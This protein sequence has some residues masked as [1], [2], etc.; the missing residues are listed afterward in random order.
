QIVGPPKRFERLEPLEGLN[1]NV[2]KV[3]MTESNGDYCNF[4]P[5]KRRTRLP[6]GYMGKILR[7]NMTSGNLTD[8]NVPEEPLLR[9]YWGGQLFAE[10]VLLNELPLEIDPYD[11]R[12]II[13]GMTGP[14]TGTGFT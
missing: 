8:L 14:V 11:P 3:F 10:Y 7:V 6:G 13:V 4:F 5:S 9:K 1:E 12:N 2:T